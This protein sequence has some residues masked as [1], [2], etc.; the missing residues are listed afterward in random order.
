M[1]RSKYRDLELERVVK[2]LVDELYKSL[3]AEDEII[4]DVFD[5]REEMILNNRLAV[6]SFLNDAW[7]SLNFEQKHITQL[8]EDLITKI[9]SHK[10]SC[11]MSF[12]KLINLYSTISKL[13]TERYR[14]LES[15]ASYTMYSLTNEEFEI[16]TMYRALKR[17]SYR[18]GFRRILAAYISRIPDI[19]KHL[20]LIKGNNRCASIKRQSRKLNQEKP[21]K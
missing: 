20:G 10:N 21:Q 18:I 15:I 17:D 13:Q 5:N 14:G 16:I 12:D 9:T 4:G 7:K 19:H 1:P 6:T 3:E 8:L 2:D 11:C